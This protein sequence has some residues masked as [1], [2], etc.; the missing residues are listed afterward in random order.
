MTEFLAEQLSTAHWFD[1][2][3]TREL[4]DWAPSVSLDEGFARLEQYYQDNPR[5]H[6]HTGSVSTE[7]VEDVADDQRAR[8][9]QASVATGSEDSNLST[10][11]QRVKSL[12]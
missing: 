7:R 9:E 3:E 10:D 4:L 6:R 12:E 11:L 2:R 1:Q 5:P 8:A